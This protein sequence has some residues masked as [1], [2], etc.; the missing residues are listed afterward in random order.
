VQKVLT[1]IF[2]VFLNDK[3]KN[4]RIE[5]METEEGKETHAVFVLIPVPTIHA[6]GMIISGSLYCRN[7][8]IR[9]CVKGFCR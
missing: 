9:C 3:K 5:V 7:Y 1:A 2:G 8:D 6:A 4:T